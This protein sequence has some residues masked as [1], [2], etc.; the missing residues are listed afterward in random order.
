MP[1]NDTE[2]KDEK[3]PKLSKEVLLSHSYS[4][5][6]GTVYNP[7]YTSNVIGS[8]ASVSMVG[9]KVS[10][11]Q[12]DQ[13]TVRTGLFTSWQKGHSYETVANQYSYTSL[14]GEKTLPL[15]NDYAINLKGQFAYFS[16]DL[17]PGG[18]HWPSDT[19]FNPE[20]RLK[21][22]DA[23]IGVSAVVSEHIAK[24]QAYLSAGYKKTQL[25]VGAYIQ[26]PAGKSSEWPMT[27]GS[28]IE[29]RTAASQ[30]VKIDAAQKLKFMGSYEAGELGQT[31]FG[32]NYT[33]ELPKSGL[34]DNWKFSAETVLSTTAPHKIA[35]ITG[36]VTMPFALNPHDAHTVHGIMSASAGWVAK[37]G[38]LTPA[39]SIGITLKPWDTRP[40]NKDVPA[41]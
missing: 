13:L 32:V 28:S 12:K 17:K 31:R 9:I 38:E 25:H 1:E 10:N 2:E 26:P 30:E 37:K 6:N 33:A 22:H 41:R 16:P 7:L 40:V 3:K 36:N 29:F 23:S 5:L 34:R 20:V 24:N 27:P 18:S 19:Y 15:K 4:N 39:F 11:A 21:H 35:H 8:D 14:I